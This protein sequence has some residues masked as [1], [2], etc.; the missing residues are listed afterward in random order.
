MLVRP[1]DAGVEVLLG[2]AGGFPPDARSRSATLDVAL[3]SAETLVSGW[4]ERTRQLQQE[5]LS[6]PVP[7]CLDHEYIRVAGWP[8][9]RNPH[10]KP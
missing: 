3:A 5:L 6:E 4:L 2:D 1:C 10:Y 8:P 9:V 7:G